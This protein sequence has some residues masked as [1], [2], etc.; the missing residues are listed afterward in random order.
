[1][2]H[3]R[4]TN[5]FKF[6]AAI[7][8]LALCLLSFCSPILARAE[9]EGGN[10]DINKDEIIDDQLKLGEYKKL[11]EHL[12]KYSDDGV[13]EIIDGFNPRN[14]FHDVAKGKFKFSLIGLLNGI[15]KFLFKEIYFNINIMIKLIIIVILCAMLRNLQNSFLS[16]SVGEL[17]FYVCYIAIVSVLITSFNTSLNLAITIIDNMVDFMYATMP[18]LITL[19]VSG[20][21]VT[22]AGAFQPIMVGII[23]V[24]ATIIKSV[25]VPLVLL[26]TVLGLIGN[27]SDKV[28]ISKLTEFI[29]QIT[30]WT[31]GFIL[32]VFIAIISIQSS[33]GAVV[34]G[35]T[36][37]TAKFAVGTFIPIAGK[38]LA[39]AADTVIG[40]ALLIKNAAGVS[41]MAGVIAICVIP[42][43][44]IA[45]LICMYKIICALVEPI[46][47]KRI[48]QCID[49]IGN[50]LTY[51]IGLVV[52]VAFMFIMSV[53]AIIAAGSLSAMI[54]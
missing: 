30:I 23:G 36:G 1:M 47:E 43:L 50:S 32:T 34:D 40:C 33:L 18:I 53:T 29:K 45:A 41:V 7:F 11:E 49:Q 4:N 9:G 52:S 38:Y 3:K 20:G 26:S 46:S 2:I 54:R 21:N 10:Y 8:S 6:Y 37:K 16:E 39:D 13:K 15:G 28:H 51:I 12:E 44:K 48:T 42:I 14:I 31:L 19:L 25:L 17:A 27:I 35:V 24:S 22:S 5:K